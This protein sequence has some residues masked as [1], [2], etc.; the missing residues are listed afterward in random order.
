[1][2]IAGK[3]I[4]G[5]W[6]GV[7]PWFIIGAV[8]IIIPFFIFVTLDSIRKQEAGTREL[9]LAQ[10]ETLIRSFEAGM[11]TGAGMNWGP[12]QL[13]KL[14]IEM[15]QQPGLDHII[16]V[17][18]E[19]AILA[20]SDPSMIGESYGLD[21]D[22]AAASRLKFPG[23]RVV[24]DSDRGETFEVFR[25]FP[26]ADQSFVDREPSP[27]AA[28]AKDQ[29]NV[30]KDLVI[31][32]GLNMGPLNAARKKELEHTTMMA[33]VLLIVALSGVLSLFLAQAY[34]SA[35]VSLTAVKA[36]SESIIGHM[37]IGL[38]AFD[39]RG[40]LLSFNQ[41][42]ERILKVS[43]REF[44]R[45]RPLSA[46]PP[47]LASLLEEMKAE[48]GR[49]ARELTIVVTGG[50][51]H[52]DVVA[53]ALKDETGVF[54][55]RLVLLRD[56]TEIRHL[57]DEVA[58]SERLVALGNLAAGVAHEI[59]NPLS[60][61]KGFATFFRER[62]RDNPEDYQTAGIMI[63]EVD[64]LNRVITQLL[65]LA[66]PASPEK[67]TVD[68]IST[69]NH[70]LQMIAARAETSGVTIMTHHPTGPLEVLGDTDQIKQ[71]LFNL[72]LNALDAMEEGGTLTVT[73]N[74][75]AAGG[76]RIV[77]E[78]TGAG[79]KAED[80]TRIFDPYFTTKPAGTGLGLAIVHKI[81]EAHRGEIHVDS[82]EGKGT[83]VTL[84]IP[85]IRAGTVPDL[86]TK[87]SEVV[88]AGLSPSTDFL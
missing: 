73:L 29:G 31:F 81:I 33:A 70:V 79:I 19:G 5:I 23:W 15:A 43:L 8:L 51:I 85:G 20:D 57:R 68:L 56:T 60:S 39:E 35:R 3:K 66:Q 75:L 18:Q 76:G 6:V 36:L 12:F 38:L 28:G 37:P 49:I 44:L 17:N 25:R 72:F 48:S 13:R 83:R 24:K 34:R 1:M 21:L 54:L 53:A 45:K 52:L 61:I 40:N 77:I 86:R 84:D 65:D 82:E 64:R 41:E 7:S 80:L 55:G 59:R 50:G 22:L 30:S 11:R 16:V 46:L 71:V 14:L 74:E 87:R 10:G 69:I 9:L 67:E 4:R 2:R 32:V 26:P 58:R 47:A 42:A 78:D 27:R 63:A 88:E 62:L